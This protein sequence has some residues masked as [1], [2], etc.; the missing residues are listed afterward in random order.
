MS[1]SA[2]NRTVLLI[3]AISI[4]VLLPILAALGAC[5]GAL[6]PLV[7]PFADPLPTSLPP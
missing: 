3:A 4:V 7:A 1:D 5:E 6:C 2:N